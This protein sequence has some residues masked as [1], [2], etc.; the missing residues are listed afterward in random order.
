MMLAWF[1][2]SEKMMSSLP[3]NVVIVARLEVNPDWK[4]M[5]AGAPLNLARRSSNCPCSESVPAMV[6]TAAG[7]N[8]ILI[9]GGLGG[10]AQLL[11]VGQPQVVVGAEVQHPLAID[12]QPRALRRVDGADVVV[13]ALLTQ[14]A[15]FVAEPLEFIGCH[16]LFVFLCKDATLWRQNDFAA[17]ARCHDL[18][19]LM[20][21][22]QLEVMRDHPASDPPRQWKAEPR[23]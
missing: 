10:V 4:E 21:F 20:E 13:Q 7:P 22:G 19:S 17:V 2:S 5:V 12:R 3:T 18:K 15:Q 23:I 9:N 14:V 8:A 11:V 16:S 6:R 1:S